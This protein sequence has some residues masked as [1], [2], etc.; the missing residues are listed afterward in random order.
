M[1]MFLPLS[2]L[3]VI[4]QSKCVILSISEHSLE[5]EYVISLGKMFQD[6]LGF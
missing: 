3:L 5:G 2:V 1:S 6:Q 4:L